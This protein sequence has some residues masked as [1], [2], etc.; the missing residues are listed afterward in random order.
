V[1]R[2]LAPAALLLAAGCAMGP[3]YQRPEIA[4]AGTAVGVAPAADSV[5]VVYDSLAA[6]AYSGR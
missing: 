6:A 1:R 2:R 5:R 4:P 3:S